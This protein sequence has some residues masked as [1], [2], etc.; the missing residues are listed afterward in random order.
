MHQY[1]IPSKKE[2]KMNKQSSV[3]CHTLVTCECISSIM[4]FKA[5]LQSEASD[6]CVRVRW[7]MEISD[8]CMEMWRVTSDTVIYTF[9][10]WHCSCV[11]GIWP[12]Y[13]ILINVLYFMTFLEKKICIKYVS[14]HVRII[15]VCVCIQ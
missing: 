9:E 3:R 2:K 14:V 8:S 12:S 4:C 13:V 5:V 1:T 15:Y 7:H 11:G 10:T 6:R